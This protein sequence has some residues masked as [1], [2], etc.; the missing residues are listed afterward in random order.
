MCAVRLRY[1]WSSSRTSETSNS[2]R[3]SARP[4]PRFIKTFDRDSEEFDHVDRTAP[5]ADHV[6]FRRGPSHQV[7][8]PEVGESARLSLLQ[9]GP[10]GPWQAHGGPAPSC[11]VLL[12]FV[13]LE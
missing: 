2:W 3:R 9:Q 8:R 10:G 6:L 5:A 13:R 12:A 1:A 4:F 11:G 7:R